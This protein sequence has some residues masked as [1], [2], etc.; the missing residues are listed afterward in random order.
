[1]ETELHS[2]KRIFDYTKCVLS[3]KCR[4]CPDIQWLWAGLGGRLVMGKWG[5]M[6]EAK[7]NK[8]GHVKHPGHDNYQSYKDSRLA[9]EASAFRARNISARILKQQRKTTATHRKIKHGIRHRMVVEK[10]ENKTTNGVRKIEILNRNFS[11]FKNWLEAL[12]TFCWAAAHVKSEGERRK[13]GKGNRPDGQD[14]LK[15]MRESRGDRVGICAGSRQDNKTRH[16]ACCGQLWLKLQGYSSTV[17]SM[18]RFSLFVTAT[19]LLLNIEGAR[20]DLG[21]WNWVNSL[22]PSCEHSQDT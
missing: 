21:E 2:I 3:V 11:H 15:D 13:S 10:S 5:K 7:V 19:A 8:S 1:M 12:A 20:A 4:R 6:A 22:S 16:V 18:G 17:L 9:I 14:I